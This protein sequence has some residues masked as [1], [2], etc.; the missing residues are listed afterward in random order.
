MLH[1]LKDM[2]H[3]AYPADD[4]EMFGASFSNDLKKKGN[5]QSCTLFK[6][7]AIEFLTKS[8]PK[9]ESYIYGKLCEIIEQ[10]DPKL[11]ITHSG[12]IPPSAIS[13]L[14]DTTGATIVCWFPDH[15]MNIGRQYLFA[16]NYD[17]LFFKDKRLVD[18]AKM[19]SGNAFYLPECCEP[20]WHKRVPLSTSERETYG[21]D[22]TIAGNL[23]YYR[24]A[25][26]EKLMERYDVKIWGPPMP[27]WLD[28]PLKRVYQNRAVTEL[29][30]AKAFNGARIVVNTFQ[31]EVAGVNLRT[32]EAAGCGAFQI[33]EYRKE[34]EELFTV[35]EEIVTFDCIDDL[36][37]K[38]DYY[39]AHPE[40]RQMIADKAYERAH[41]EHNYKKRLTQ[42]L[43][44]L[45][46]ENA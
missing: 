26:F 41:G 39:L 37:E 15:A 20:K 42:M 46:F 7:R 1:A 10:Y 28:S 19:I 45:G 13:R 3:D 29:E 40:E 30:K 38:V 33:S 44:L 35:G 5:L 11:I 6:L 8:V 23:Y 9:F 36:V 22:V 21:C 4:R 24:A 25:I 14:K 2:G 16:G 32:F 43:E 31:G 17:A 18:M 27:R 12:W 34:I